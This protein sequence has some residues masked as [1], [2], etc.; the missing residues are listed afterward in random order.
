MNPFNAVLFD[1][2]GTLLDTLADLGNSANSV[3]MAQGLPP[4][5][6]EAYKYFVGDGAHTLITRILPEDRRGPE[7]VNATLEAFLKS[8]GANW[9]RETRLYDGIRD[10]LGHLTARGLKTAVLSNKPDDFTRL[11]VS[12]FFPDHSFDEVLGQ[13][14]SRPKKPDPTGARNIATLLDIPA[15]S[16]LYLGDTSIDMQTAVAAGMHPVGALWGFR[17]RE[18]LLASGARN[19]ISHPSELLDLLGS[20]Y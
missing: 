4:H 13:H 14:P 11:C 1:L 8:Y 7:T 5:P 3:L 15:A 17:P 2:D 10:M 6:L 9:T 16:F 20:R 18:E 19:L 12:R